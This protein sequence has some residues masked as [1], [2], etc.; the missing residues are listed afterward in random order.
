MNHFADWLRSANLNH[1]ET[2]VEDNLCAS[3]NFVNVN[4]GV[5]RY[6]HFSAVG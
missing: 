4:V 2:L 6:S 1:I 5:D 3:L